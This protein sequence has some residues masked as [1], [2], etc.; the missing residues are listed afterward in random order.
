MIRSFDLSLSPSLLT[1]SP[2]FSSHAIVEN[3]E[4]LHSTQSPA[5]QLYKALREKNIINAEGYLNP[6][7]VFFRPSFFETYLARMKGFLSNARLLDLLGL[8]LE[9]DALTYGEIFDLLITIDP[10][11]FILVLKKDA[12]YFLGFEAID[13]LYKEQGVD[14]VKICGAPFVEAL[15]KKIEEEPS[16]ILIQYFLEQINPLKIAAL[17]R[18]IINLIERKMPFVATDSKIPSNKKNSEDEKIEKEVRETYEKIEKEVKAQLLKL[19]KRN[20]GQW[21]NNNDKFFLIIKNVIA[22]SLAIFNQKEAQSTS[23]KSRARF[24]MRTRQKQV[25]QIE[26][27]RSIHASTLSHGTDNIRLPLC[28]G[29][30]EKES[31]YNNFYRYFPSLV[32]GMVDFTCRNITSLPFKSFLSSDWTNG[33]IE[34]ALGSTSHIPSLHR[35]RAHK[36][37]AMA[38][39]KNRRQPEISVGKILGQWLQ[40]GFEKLLLE[41]NIQEEVQPEAA[42]IFTLA[43][44]DSLHEQLS[45][46]ELHSVK[47]ALSDYYQPLHSRQQSP[48]YPILKVLKLKIPYPFIATYLQI[49]ALEQ[50]QTDKQCYFTAEKNEKTTL[51]SDV[52]IEEPILQL[53]FKLDQADLF[54]QVE[55]SAHH[56]MRNLVFRPENYKNLEAI[57]MALLGMSPKEDFFGSIS[58]PLESEIFSLFKQVIATIKSKPNSSSPWQLFNFF[59]ELLNVKN[60]PLNQHEKAQLKSLL[61]SLKKHKKNSFLGQIYKFFGSMHNPLLN[62]AIYNVFKLEEDENLRII[63]ARA[64]C[65][66]SITYAC[67]IFMRICKSPTVPIKTKYELLDVICGNLQ[68]ASASEKM[69]SIEILSYDMGQ[70]FKHPHPLTHAQWLSMQFYQQENNEFAVLASACIESEEKRR[71]QQA[72]YQ[73]SQKEKQPLDP[74]EKI[75]ALLKEEDLKHFH[76]ISLFLKGERVSQTFHDKPD[77]SWTTLALPALRILSGSHIFNRELINQIASFLL[78]CI[79]I[80]P[81]KSTKVEGFQLLV[82]KVIALLNVSE[83]D[84]RRSIKRILSTKGD[85]IFSLCATSKMGQEILELCDSM[86][87]KKIPLSIASADNINT[88]INLC[89]AASTPTTM[90]LLDKL[91][92]NSTFVELLKNCPTFKVASI[93]LKMSQ[94]YTELDF[95]LALQAFSN[96]ANLVKKVNKPQLEV[97]LTHAINHN[98]ERE[99]ALLTDKMLTKTPSTLKIWQR[100]FKKLFLLSEGLNDKQ[101]NALTLIINNPLFKDLLK[102]P[103][104]SILLI[105]KLL[106]MDK[107]SDQLIKGGEL[108]LKLVEMGFIAEK[109]I[110]QL[111]GQLKPNKE[112]IEQAW[113]VLKNLTTLSEEKSTDCILFLLEKMEFLKTHVWFSIL[114]CRNS[115][116]IFKSD[117]S[118][119]VRFVIKLFA[120][121]ARAW[122]RFGTA[123]HLS[124]IKKIYEKIVHTGATIRKDLLQQLVLHYAECLSNS[125][126]L[127]D[128]EF[129]VALLGYAI[130][131]GKWEKELLEGFKLILRNLAPFKVTFKAVM[132]DLC[133]RPN[134]PAAMI[135]IN[136]LVKYRLEGDTLSMITLLKF[137][138]E[139]SKTLPSEESGDFIAFCRSINLSKVLKEMAI[140]ADV[141]ANDLIIESLNM[142]EMAQFIKDRESILFSAFLNIFTNTANIQQ[143]LYAPRLPE[144][145]TTFE[146]NFFSFLSTFITHCKKE[147][148]EN[149]L[150]LFFDYIHKRLYINSD[151]QKYTEVCQ[152]TNHLLKLWITHTSSDENA[153]TYE[154]GPLFHLFSQSLI[155]GYQRNISAPLIEAFNFHLEIIQKSLDHPKNH[156]PDFFKKL[157]QVAFLLHRLEKKN[158][159]MEK[160]I[161]APIPLLDNI[162]KPLK[163]INQ[164][165][166]KN[167]REEKSLFE[168]VFCEIFLEPPIDIV[169]KIKRPPVGSK[170]SPKRV[171][172]ITFEPNARIDLLLKLLQEENSEISLEMTCSIIDSNFIEFMVHFKSLI[173][174][175]RKI[176]NS[177]ENYPLNIQCEIVY[178]MSNF[179]LIIDTQLSAKNTANDRFFKA[180][181]AIRKEIL[182]KSISLFCLDSSLYSNVYFFFL[183]YPRIL[184][185]N[186]FCLEKNIA[187]FYPI[188]ETSLQN[189]LKMG[190]R[191]L[192]E[193][194]SFD[195]FESINTSFCRTLI[196]LESCPQNYVNIRTSLLIQWIEL[197]QV[198][199]LRLSNV[200]FIIENS[201]HIGLNYNQKLIQAVRRVFIYSLD[202]LS[203]EHKPKDFKLIAL[204]Y[205][206]MLQSLVMSNSKE[207]D[208]KKRAV[209]VGE[210]I[211]DLLEAGIPS[212]QGPLKL[213]VILQK[214]LARALKA[215]VYHNFSN[216][217]ELYR[218]HTELLL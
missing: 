99:F 46:E 39:D 187:E 180:F 130:K 40:K 148:L 25:I 190:E 178:D 35:V 107:E 209:L 60:S 77:E 49:A 184:E 48:F 43:A 97:L 66:G 23:L 208:Y 105:N 4:V 207:E 115:F 33:L 198:E 125:S 22:N 171:V 106:E 169:P 155:S 139:H 74:L 119:R 56:L 145:E 92:S 135:L 174:L 120:G 76:Q 13:T 18:G 167:K 103:K 90:K 47:T 110:V 32:Q 199:T 102:Q 114:E 172:N 108:A 134:Y 146:D 153:T 69:Q 88:G 21:I 53:R 126:E 104:H 137:L 63:A 186:K 116:P 216:A 128:Q 9:I 75:T 6:A 2:V 37:I 101:L 193:Q 201:F 71:I 109:A 173:L 31:I 117:T 183:Y 214:A 158:E 161:K 84:Y 7:V 24:C 188:F 212:T 121:L 94:F 62:Q 26:F 50:L 210:W 170:A 89:L 136:A 19:K 10:A 12:L 182:R 159:D 96:Y 124:H 191:Y 156:H 194:D 64:L 58:L 133:D 20:Y 123:E 205:V 175:F 15:K 176:L 143:R 163:Q 200:K 152:K 1:P 160:A 51:H 164:A 118:L 57:S 29:Q 100:G 154:L 52:V 82:Q 11:L 215:K 150:T 73:E 28:K 5:L 79:E 54:I 34:M 151:F 55:N 122:R 192:K 72:I 91:L 8:N 142:P 44:L 129:V 68:K 42:I 85:D 149:L 61:G 177:M 65:M 16:Y 203:L 197:I 204:S 168:R 81:Y 131:E 87:T 36:A 86:L 67:N 78:T 3:E 80:F 17:E 181:E 132:Q 30:E 95:S 185:N 27:S 38:M 179:F 14:M 93:Y 141:P 217:K 127:E 138:I 98:L 83:T 59:A 162:E 147:S 189:Y 195:E 113:E 202:R 45:A 165:L 218:A 213:K 206:E 211:Q 144:E 70:L 112:L 111:Y 157:A 196:E 166:Q 140:L 41:E